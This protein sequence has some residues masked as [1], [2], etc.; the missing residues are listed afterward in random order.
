MYRYGKILNQRQVQVMKEI[1]LKINADNKLSHINPEISVRIL[2]AESI[3]S[4]NTFASPDRVTVKELSVSYSNN[5]V[6][7]V[8]PTHSVVSLSAR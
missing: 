4:H 5:S 2:T 1:T 8:V 7:L 3:H 6:R